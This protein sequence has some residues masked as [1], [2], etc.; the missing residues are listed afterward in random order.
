MNL[1]ILIKD[2][3]IDIERFRDTDITH[4]TYDSRDVVQG[5]LFIA[6]KGSR[7]D[8]NEFISDAIKSGAAAV[9]TESGNNCDAENTVISA[10]IAKDMALI[11]QRFYGI[12]SNDFNMFGI[13]GTNGKTTTS[14]VLKSILDNYGQTGLIG[15]I[16]HMIGNEIIKAE[17]TTP[18]ALIT[19]RLMKQ[20]KDAGIKN[21][22]ME[23]SSHGLKLNRVWGLAFDSVIFTNLTQDHLD[24]HITMDDYLQSKLKLFDMLKQGAHSIV[25]ADDEH[26]MQFSSRSG[27]SHTVGLRNR[28]ADWLI[29]IQSLSI[30][31]SRFTLSNCKNGESYELNIDIIGDYNIYNTAF[32]FLSAYYN[33]IEGNIISEQI[34]TGKISIPGRFEKFT[35]D[36]G[37]TAIVDYAHTPDA[38]ERVL[39]TARRLTHGNLITVFGCGGDRDRD[40]RP[41]M[42][43]IA[44]HYSNSLII[45]SD[46]PRTEKPSTI[47]EDIIRGISERNYSVEINRKQA[48]K[49]ALRSAKQGD[50]VVIAGKGHETYQLINNNVYHFDDREEVRKYL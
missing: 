17:N 7:S 42:G 18:D 4:I 8:G 29:D 25:N 23:V 19:A 44:S 35:S 41:I 33:G 36:N 3:N 45:T 20:M 34:N 49:R 43:K 13:T 22:I 50:T 30:N 10:D 28:N 26:H 1:S 24:F 14:Y 11:S 15:T 31:G 46:N 37:I 16:R 6:L 9:L 5:S 48:I 27:S 40:K 38:L 12:N 39:K 32:A 47:I 2:M 21:I